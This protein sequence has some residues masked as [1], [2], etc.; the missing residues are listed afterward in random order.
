MNEILPR[1]IFAAGI[2]Q[3]GILAASALVPFQLDWKRELASLPRLHKQM[4]FIY[5][6]Y[7]VLGIITLGVSSLLYSAELATGSGLARVFCIYATLFW[8]IRLCLQGV[9]DA[10]PFLTRWW[11]KCGYHLLT[12]LF[13]GITIVF[14]YATIRSFLLS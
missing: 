12:V 10:R 13:A 2:G 6:G 1:L 9:L 3:L 7:V 5:G 8:G 4:Y 14:G 11:L